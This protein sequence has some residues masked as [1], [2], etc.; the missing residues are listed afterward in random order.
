[1]SKLIELTP[2][3]AIYHYMLP[4]EVAKAPLNS[5][6]GT[7]NKPKNGYDDDPWPLV[8]FLQNQKH[9][10]FFQVCTLHEEFME[11][12][13]FNPLNDTHCGYVALRKKSLKSLSKVL[14]K[15]SKKLAPNIGEQP[16]KFELID[17]T[18]LNKYRINT[19]KHPKTS[20]YYWRIRQINDDSNIRLVFFSVSTIGGPW[21]KNNDRMLVFLQFQEFSTYSLNDDKFIPLG[22]VP[23][24]MTLNRSELIEL[25]SIIDQIVKNYERNSSRVFRLFRYLQWWRIDRKHLLLW[26]GLLR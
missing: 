19:K 1:M 4:A 25:S 5:F 24:Q 20:Q 13:D 9:E 3:Q 2:D 10:L 15:E 26:L 12:S 16:A 8:A 18:E 21:V 11:F 22:F 23:S 6:Y 7:D 14:I 17:S